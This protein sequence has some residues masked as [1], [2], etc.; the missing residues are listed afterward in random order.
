MTQDATI[1]SLIET[2]LNDAFAPQALSVI[3]ESHHH[4]GHAGWREGGETHFRVKVTAEAFRGLSR[5]DTHRRI[6]AALADAFDRGL[7]AL[8]IEAKAP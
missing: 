2:R 5:V 1:K 6:N 8:A 4:H 3:D 7:H